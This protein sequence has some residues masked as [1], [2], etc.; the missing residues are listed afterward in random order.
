MDGYFKFLAVGN[1]ACCFV[2]IFG[3]FRRIFRLFSTYVRVLSAFPDLYAASCLT[4]DIYGALLYSSIQHCDT[5]AYLWRYV[6]AFLCIIHTTAILA[7]TEQEPLE[8]PKTEAAASE[9]PSIKPEEAPIETEGKDP[10][11]EHAAGSV[12]SYCSYCKVRK[13]R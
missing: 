11:K 4:Y 6:L 10:E 13:Q 5:M 2:D 7:E 12:C 1:K 8:Q 3:Y 9:S